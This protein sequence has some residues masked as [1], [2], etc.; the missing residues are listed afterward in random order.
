MYKVKS[1]ITNGKKTGRPQ[2]EWDGKITDQCKA[3]M[4]YSEQGGCK[5]NLVDKA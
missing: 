3:E 5:W 4:S 1:S 2:R